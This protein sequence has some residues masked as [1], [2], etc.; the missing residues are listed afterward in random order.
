[1]L[2]SND[3]DGAFTIANRM[4][5][6]L[7]ARDPQEEDRFFLQHPG[8]SELGLLST[9][10]LSPLRAD[11]RFVPIAERVGLLRYWRE[12]HLPDFCRGAPEPVCARIAHG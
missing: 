12:G 5:P 2:R 3:L 10:A 8:R 9:P 11:P 4:F 1:M 6:Q 7:V